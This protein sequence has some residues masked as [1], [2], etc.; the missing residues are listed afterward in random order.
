MGHVDNMRKICLSF[1]EAI[2]KETWGHPTF[3]INDK[4][5]AMCS[6]DSTPDPAMTVKTPPGEQQLLLAAGDRFFYPAYV[7]SKG[8]IGIKLSAATDWSEIHELVDDSYRLIA[9]KRLVKEL[10]T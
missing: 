5:F 10:G 9:P 3:R 7:G 1:P 4:M 6:T 2:E 8:W